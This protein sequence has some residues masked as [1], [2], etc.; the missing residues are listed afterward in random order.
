MKEKLALSWSGGK[1]ACMALHKLQEQG[2]EVAVLITTV[3]AEMGR[4]FGHGEKSEMVA[5]QGEAL[6]I[7]VYFIECTYASYQDSFV[8]ALIHLKEE[9]GITGIAYG[10][11]YLDEHREWGVD[12][13]N[14]AGLKAYYPLWTKKEDSFEALR[15][16]VYSGY[17]AMVIRVRDDALDQSWIGRELD[18][19]FVEDIQKEEICPMG[20]SGEYHTFVYDGPLFNRKILLEKGRVILFERS[21][22]LEFMGFELA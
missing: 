12:V 3:P 14:E 2:V 8:N 17:K 21:R 20:E 4:T 10:D 1:D 15:R 11:L 22:K 5:L 13:A 18:D 9:Y 7:P 19:K 16:F 6:N